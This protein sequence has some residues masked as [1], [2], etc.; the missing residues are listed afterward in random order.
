MLSSQRASL[1]SSH[2]FGSKNTAQALSFLSTRAGMAADLDEHIGL[3]NIDRI[4]SH[5]GQEDRIYLQ[6]HSRLS[7]NGPCLLL[8][9]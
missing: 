6:S 3:W 1:P 4:V 7:G 8:D 9:T 5:L 2:L